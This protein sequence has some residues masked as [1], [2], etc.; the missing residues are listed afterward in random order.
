MTF[1]ILTE[2]EELSWD[3]PDDTEDGITTKV[4]YRR[5]GRTARQKAVAKVGKG[6]PIEKW[7]T[8]HHR[9]FADEVLKFGYLRIEGGRDGSGNAIEEVPIES[10]L[11]QTEDF[12]AILFKK[13]L[14]S[15]LKGLGDLGNLFGT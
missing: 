3:L 10:I 6:K 1:R 8:S 15:G 12:R 2:D 13:I 14:G 7:A 9:E 4:I 11:E 5:M